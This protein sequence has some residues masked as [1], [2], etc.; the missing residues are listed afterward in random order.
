MPGQ[1]N[2]DKN[3]Y[4]VAPVG[5]IVIIGRSLS[6]RGGMS[7]EQAINLLT[8]LIISTSATP[9]EIKAGL[10][11]AMTGT[12]RPGQ[13]NA[14]NVPKAVARVAAEV[15]PF[16]G[17]LDPDE[18][19]AIDAAVQAQPV[20]QPVTPVQTRPIV[21]PQAATTAKKETVKTVDPDA[22]ANTWK[23]GGNG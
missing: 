13:R 7:R 2:P 22:I 12:V 6:L 5:H 9:E 16:V 23:G 15:A 8:W 3:L 10:D 4:S 19:A 1:L 18:V 14:V 20:A 17:T 11:D 21:Q